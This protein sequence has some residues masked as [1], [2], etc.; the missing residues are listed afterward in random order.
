MIGFKVKQYLKEGN[1]SFTDVMNMDNF[2]DIICDKILNDL[3]KEQKLDIIWD[4]VHKQSD[5]PFNKLVNI[6][7]KAEI[8]KI[9]K[10]IFLE[11]LENASISF[12]EDVETIS[13]V[14][15]PVESVDLDN[16]D[17]DIE[18]VVEELTP[19]EEKTKTIK[20]LVKANREPMSVDEM[21][22]E[23]II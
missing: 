22:K 8:A 16:K 18:Q 10:E 21:K 14:E 23:G 20:E 9:T 7:V 3:T 4:T 1:F 17:E 13:P 11:Y 15:A 19:L 12:N 5:L 2:Q 6:Y